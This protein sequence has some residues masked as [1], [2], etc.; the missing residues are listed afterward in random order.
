M[1]LPELFVSLCEFEFPSEGVASLQ[2]KELPLV[3]SAG[4]RLASG[5]FFQYLF[6][7]VFILL[8]F[9]KDSYAGYR[10]LSDSFVS[11]GSVHMSSRC[12]LMPVVSDGGHCPYCN[13]SLIH[14][15]SFRCYCFQVSS[16]SV[17]QSCLMMAWISVFILLGICV[18]SWI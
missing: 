17:S 4:G 10:I 13:G 9:L 18:G 14:H 8:Y 15:E 6:G 5:R 1:T 16:L 2:P 3:F 12:L 11:F 7:N